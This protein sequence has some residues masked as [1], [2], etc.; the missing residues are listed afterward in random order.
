MI[1]HP[2]KRGGAEDRIEGPGKGQVCR[3]RPHEVHQVGVF[4]SVVQP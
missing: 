4:R 2:M 1:P 3:I